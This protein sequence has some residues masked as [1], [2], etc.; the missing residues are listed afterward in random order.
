VDRRFVLFFAII[1]IYTV[2]YQS[3][4]SGYLVSALINLYRGGETYIS[5]G[6][7]SV[8]V[9]GGRIFLE[10]VQYVTEDFSFKAMQLSFRV[11]WWL[12]TSGDR[13][14]IGSMTSQARMLLNE[15]E[16]LSISCYCVELLIFNSQS[17]YDALAKLAR[18]NEKA[19]Q[20]TATQARPTR[21][22]RCCFSLDML[23]FRFCC[24]VFVL[25]HSP[26]WQAKYRGD[27]SDDER[28]D[29]GKHRTGQQAAPPPT[30]PPSA[31]FTT[32][33]HPPTCI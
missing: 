8:A 6:S 22:S 3:Y 26:I 2:Y 12:K 23:I 19:A 21:I 18:K 4:V 16:R 30:A 13:M 9:L 33:T 25:G 1:T 11:Q 27:S 31:V 24:A 5:I 29:K 14:A 7:I 15:S 20:D 17:K 10:D 32:K 28:G